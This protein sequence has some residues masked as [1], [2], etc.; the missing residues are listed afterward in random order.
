MAL[1]VLAISFGTNAQE[2]CKLKISSY[3]EVLRCAEERSPEVQTAL[4][5][6]ERARIQIQVSTQWKNPEF[7]AESVYGSNHSD[8][9]SETELSLGV[10][11][12]LGGK[13]SARRAVAEAHVAKAEA[14]LLQARSKAR[15]SALLKLHRLR[16]ALHELEVV[17]ESISTFSKL[18]E[19]YRKRP[20]LSPEQA[21]SA[22]VFRMTKSDYELKKMS[23]SDETA[24]LKTYLKVHLGADLESLK[25]DLPPSPKTWPVVD[26]KLDIALSP[27]VRSI[28]AQLESAQAELSL[29]Q[30]ESW[31]T[32]SIGPSLKIQNEAGISTQLY[33]VNLSFDL[34]IFN[35]NGPARAAAAKSVKI[36]ETHKSF[37]HLKEEQ[38][39]EQL[40]QTY[41][42]SIEALDATLSHREIEKKHT[43]VERL[44]LKGVVPSSLVI[45]AHRSFVELEQ[46]RNE[47]EM[48][49]LEALMALYAM[50]GKMPEAIP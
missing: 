8:N 14:T 46:S 5:E 45:E 19:R 24:D 47:R 49:A 4:L 38:L 35:L 42:S 44:F 18:A 32:L 9:I 23:I 30:S 50:N 10:P 29:A 34:P 22:T 2:P 39:F 7:G 15:G 28:Q 40:Y 3:R 11:I 37:A 36:A 43:S 31:P 16:Q 41:K 21:M 26:R 17:E 1:S 27:R 33:G 13:R 25:K 48:K 6:L 20:K 12:E